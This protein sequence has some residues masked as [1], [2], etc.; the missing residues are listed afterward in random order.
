MYFMCK[1]LAKIRVFDVKI[2]KSNIFTL[3][4]LQTK[5]C[6]FNLK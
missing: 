6:G 2:A 5:I 4:F 3:K 1:F